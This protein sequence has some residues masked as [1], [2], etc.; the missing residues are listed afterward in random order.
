MSLEP[1][2]VFCAK[3]PAASYDYCPDV[4]FPELPV[5]TKVTTALVALGR[6]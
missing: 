5:W 6:Y 1:N 4:R 3:I 2:C